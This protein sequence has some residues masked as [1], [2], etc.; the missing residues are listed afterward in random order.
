[1]Q[2]RGGRRDECV[3]GAA[4]G[5]QDLQGRGAGGEPG[6]GRA[7]GNPPNEPGQVKKAQTRPAVSQGEEQVPM[8]STDTSLRR[9]CKR[10][11]GMQLQDRKSVE[12]VDLAIETLL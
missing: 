10:S 8:K 9:C 3:R 1:M 5:R 2:E 4:G 7:A 6:E 11:F 12:S